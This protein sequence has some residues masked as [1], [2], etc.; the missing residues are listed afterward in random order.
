M[1]IRDRFR[2]EA[3]FILAKEGRGSGA[4]RAGLRSFARGAPEPCERGPGALREG[5]RSFARG[6]PEL[7]TSGAPEPRAGLR[8]NFNRPK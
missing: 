6:A 5:L 1:C 2:S 4:L 8:S 7:F 3:H